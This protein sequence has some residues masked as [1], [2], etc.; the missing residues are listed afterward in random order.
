MNWGNRIIVW[1]LLLTGLLFG[2]CQKQQ[3]YPDEVKILGH[4]GMG[5]FNAYPINSMESVLL[6]KASG[7]HGVEIDL[8]MS[9]DGVLVAFHDEQMDRSTNL[10][11]K[12]Y[13]KTWS[14]LRQAVYTTQPY[15]AYR[16]VSLEQ[17]FTELEGADDFLISLDCKSFHG[18]DTSYFPKMEEALLHLIEKYGMDNRV[19]IESG[20]K[21]FLSSLRSRSGL[22]LFL[23][24]N[25][26]DN[27]AS[28]IR[29]GGFTGLSIDFAAVSAEAV[30]GLRSEGIKV[31]LINAQSRRDN[32]EALGKQPDLIQTDRLK[33]LLHAL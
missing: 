11:G 27:A 32:Q 10:S 28:V 23:L 26:L 29:G 9:R 7:A 5:I 3:V 20:N 14:A 24:S 16:V 21:T 2:A 22:Q 13:D 15:Q 12:V 4:G 19:L 33:P 18:G 6:A 31:M 30:A 25:D 8:Q 17:V 1:S